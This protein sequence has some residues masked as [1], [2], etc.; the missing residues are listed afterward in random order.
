MTDTGPILVTGAAGGLGGV[1]R[2]VVE[3][4]VA[5]SLPVRAMAHRDDE[6]AD[7]LRALGVPVVVG[8]LARPEDV[9]RALDGCRRMFFSMS[10]SPEYLEAAATVADVARAVGGAA[11]DGAGGLET[12]VAMS[13]LTVS[14]M[15]ALRL[16]ES[17]QQR[18][19][20]L[21]EQVLDW[22]GLPVT[23][24][25]PTAFLESPLFSA[26]AAY[27]LRHDGTLS[28]PFGSGRTS[29]MAARD[30]AR[31]VAELLAEPQAHR[32]HV[33][34]LTGPRS[35]D[36]TGVAEEYSRALGRDIPYVDVPPQ[37]WAEHVL[38]VAGLAPHARQHILTL[39]RMHHENR[40]DRL[41]RIVEQVTGFPPQTV[42]SY[43]AEHRDQFTPVASR[44]TAG[45]GG[46]RR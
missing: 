18:L 14:Q 22:S 10:V 25:R 33:Y 40:F 38:P 30:V 4:L 5:R 28:L 39:A 3:L 2:S 13:Q 46:W 34:E 16:R 23:H 20:W 35:Q 1:G 24:V 41:T 21:S 44:P 42:E 36:M 27:T 26:L 29:P 37:W 7:A 32:E 45:V 15:T 43:V 17:R 6:R 19:H 8:D 31:V 12:L 11:G 9:A